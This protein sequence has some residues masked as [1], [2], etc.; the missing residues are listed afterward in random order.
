MID[1]DLQQ[2]LRAR[3]NPDGSDIR[4]LQLEMLKMLLWFDDFC[5][6]HNIRYWL[7]S[8]TLLGA[9]RHGGYIP[10]DDDLDIDM[11]REDYDKL[12]AAML[13]LDDPDYAL[14]DNES[15]P[16]YFF[17]YGKLRHKHSLMEETNRYD[18]I[19]NMKGMFIDILTFEKM[20][21]ILNKI[22]CMSVGH[23]YKI[24]NRPGIS[25]E[26]ALR[27]VQR[28]YR[29]NKHLLFP[30]LR[31]IAKCAP[32]KW[33][34]RSPGIPYKSRTTNDEVFPTTQIEFE[35]HSFP[36][37]RDTHSYLTR[38]YGDYMQ[39]PDIENL[40]PHFATFTINS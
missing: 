38:M 11:M 33:R 10:W 28:I 12:K 4:T 20:P 13:N 30:T 1:K 15:D 16:G 17:S 21:R 26:K 25:D 35:G 14:Q 6:K 2:E 36:A 34:F 31:L 24:L 8:G 32:T 3:F 7:S 19:F 39:L 29:F 22:A 23:S 37:P 5:K 9:V 40:H 18:R 27:K